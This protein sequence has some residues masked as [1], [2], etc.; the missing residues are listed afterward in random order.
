MLFELVSILSAI[1]L[2]Y[3]NEYM[4]KEHKNWTSLKNF[5]PKINLNHNIYV[6]L[7]FKWICNAMELIGNNSSQVS[8]HILC[9]LQ[10]CMPDQTPF[11]FSSHVF[12]LSVKEIAASVLSVIS[13]PAFAVED[14]NLVNDAREKIITK[15]Q[16]L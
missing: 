3:G 13:F 15:L 4:I 16:V 8:I 2:H 9:T 10:L 5:A 6:M 11:L 1:V 14:E 7:H 12:Q